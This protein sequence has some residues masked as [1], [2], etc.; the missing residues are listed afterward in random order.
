[1]KIDIDDLKQVKGIGEKTIERIKDTFQKPKKKRFDKVDVKYGVVNNMDFRQGLENID[2]EFMI[3]T[4]PPYNIEYEYDNYSD[5]LTFAEYVSLIEE[6][7]G[8]K[9]AIIHYPEEAMRYFVPAL[10]VPDEVNVWAYNSNLPNRHHRLINYYNVKP[11]YNQV[12]QPFKNPNDKRIQERIKNGVKGAR[13]YDWF[14]DIQLVKNV[15]KK[16][17]NHPC[18]VPVELMKRIILLT[19]NEGDL[20]VDPFAGSGTTAIACLETN[21]R[22]VGFE[23]SPNYTEMAN[24]RIQEWKR[25]ND[26]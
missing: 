10:G 19:T 12:L 26:M 15:S 3:V 1:M 2:E 25:K 20:V 18:P 16:E 22:F 14:T 11:D 24:R 13:S 7:K 21:R 6:F 23:L 5:D 4:D 17:Y 9:L 8:F